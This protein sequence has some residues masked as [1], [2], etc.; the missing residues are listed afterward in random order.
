[1]LRETIVVPYGSWRIGTH[2]DIRF[3]W[4]PNERLSLTEDE[5]RRHNE[6]GGYECIKEFNRA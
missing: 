2:G 1:M 6:L 5:Q 3:Y 4:E